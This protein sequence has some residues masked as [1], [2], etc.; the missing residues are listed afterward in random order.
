MNASE[1]ARATTQTH[2]S[3]GME[4]RARCNIVVSLQNVTCSLQK[5]LISHGK[6]VGS[7]NRT[8]EP[9]WRVP[10]QAKLHQQVFILC[11]G[12]DKDGRRGGVGGVMGSEGDGRQWEMKAVASYPSWFVEL[13]GRREW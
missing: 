10:Q 12:D 2:R 1:K 5:M 13:P 9:M 8:A 4:M 11:T 3:R 7:K 6:S